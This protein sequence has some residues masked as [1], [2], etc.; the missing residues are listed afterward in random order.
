VRIAVADWARTT[1]GDGNLPVEAAIAFP[2]RLS[3]VV[4]EEPDIEVITSE[5]AP[6]WA[7]RMGRVQR[8][9][10]ARVVQFADA[11]VTASRRQAE[12]SSQRPKAGPRPGASRAAG[13]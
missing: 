13:A 10:A 7:N 9:D 2:S 12:N 6:W 3:R 11:V 8:M 5:N 1:L 4:L